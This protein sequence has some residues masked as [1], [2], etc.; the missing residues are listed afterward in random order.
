MCTAMA[1]AATAL[2]INTAQTAASFIGQ[3]NMAK[4]QARFQEKQ[5]AAA[6]EA[7]RANLE[8]LGLMRQQDISAASD[9]QQ[10]VQREALQARSRAAT[11]AGEAGVSGNSI[12]MLLREFQARELNF[13]SNIAENVKRR[14]DQT[15]RE[16]LSARAGAQSQVNMARSPIEKPSFLDAGLRIAGSAFGAYNQFLH[17]PP[18]GSR[19]S[20]G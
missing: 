7:Y 2:G 9:Q 6:N 8:A 18:K 10:E 16:M 20:I 1:M 12:D 5:G 14:S 13:N 3:S 17:I 4:A 19:S 11:A 15:D